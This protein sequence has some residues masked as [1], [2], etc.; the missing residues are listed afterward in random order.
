[1]AE[2][3][4]TARNIVL[5]GGETL[6][7]L[8][9]LLPTRFLGTHR[10]KKIPDNSSSR[11][12]NP[13][14]S[15]PYRGPTA[16][17][18][19]LAFSPP[20]ASV[21]PSSSPGILFAGSWDKRIYSW[22]ARTRA[23]QR[24]YA[25]GHT[26]FVKALVTTALPP[27]ASSSSPS[28][29]T[30]IAVLISGGA[31]ARIVI[32]N[33]TTGEKLHVL[34]SRESSIG[35]GVLA[36]AILPRFAP[37]SPPP[38]REG[39]KK[40]EEEEEEPITLFAATSLPPIRRYTLDTTGSANPEQ[41]PRLTELAPE[42]PISVHETSVYDLHFDGEGDLWTASADGDI[43]CLACEKGWRVE[44]RIRSGGWLRGV[45]VGGDGGWVVGVGRDEEVRV[46]EQAVSFCLFF[47]LAFAFW[48][49]FAF[50]R[51]EGGD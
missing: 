39:Q 46:W 27:P 22:N 5:D 8:F 12:D 9:P 23:P 36:L 19:C 24:T 38:L 3:T 47:F 50:P 20:S 44:L 14:P 51:R 33:M 30:P 1:M 25:N 32:W 45:A 15:A 28:G 16:P 26:D 17:A 2:S 11:I 43:T 34:K 49:Y 37:S 7:P 42:T 10:E 40:K 35:G 6:R 21:S 31:D 48:L 41:H 18:T 13:T 29:P 4:G